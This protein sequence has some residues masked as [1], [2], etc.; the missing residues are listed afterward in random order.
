MNDLNLF[1]YAGRQVR[2]VTINGE[3][4]F[5][6]KDVCEILGIAN[7]RDAV[8]RLDEDGVGSADVIDSM[9]RRQAAHTVNE[10]SLY[11]LVFQSRKPEAKDFRRWVTREVLPSIRRTGH[12]GAVKMSG[13]ELMAAALLEAQ[14]T[15][16]EKDFQIEAQSK[17]IEAAA[18]K[19]DY[20][21]QF[22]ADGDL[23]KFRAVAASIGIGEQALRELLIEK[24]WIY[25]DRT[26]RW[27]NSKGCKEKICRYSAYADKKRYFQPVMNHDAPRFR[28]EVMHTLKVTPAGAT[29]IAKLVLG[30]GVVVRAGA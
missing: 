3:P 19:V 21:D 20:V 18:P 8:S 30:S 26:E 28:G 13:K 4:W 24:R 14:A 29:A 11:E 6:A 9:S 1:N 15:M 25:A 2:T 27:S 17:V 10:S 7:A 12:Y 22:V 5:V 23:L 16:A